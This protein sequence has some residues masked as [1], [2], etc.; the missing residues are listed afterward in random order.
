MVGHLVSS[1]EMGSAG[2]GGEVV[3]YEEMMVRKRDVGG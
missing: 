3:R 2:G 1:E